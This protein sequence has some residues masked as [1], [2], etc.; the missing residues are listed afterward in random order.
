M[1]QQG[2]TSFDREAPALVLSAA[3]LGENNARVHVLTEE[4]GLVRGVVYGARSR[5]GSALWQ[6][7]NLVKTRFQ[8]RSAGGIVRLSGELLYGCGF[9]LLDAPLTLAMVQSVCVL[10]DAAL[11]EG[12]PCPILF[13]KTVKLLSFLG[14]DPAVSEREGLPD[15][16]RWECALLTELGFGL[17]FSACAVTGAT[18]G[19]AY[20]SPKTGK[21]VS[22]DGAGEWKDRLLPLPSFLLSEEETGTPE[23]WLSG[24]RLT[25]HFLA[26]DAFGQRHRPLPAA[27][28]RLVDRVARLAGQPNET[29]EEEGD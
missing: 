5:A 28:E 22:E 24:L 15:V 8:A 7:G 16:V 1:M 17:D 12:E 13:A 29:P 11:P 25:G 9:R 3:L 27:R 21:A 19:L 14:F 10:A 2:G 4:N 18:T 20:V 23:D 26:R 6:P